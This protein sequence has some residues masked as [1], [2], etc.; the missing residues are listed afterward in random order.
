MRLLPLAVL[1]VGLVL[2]VAAASETAPALMTVTGEGEAVAVPDMASLSL[3]VATRGTT[4]AKALGANST[5]LAAV[6]AQLAADG[7][8][9]RDIQTSGLSVSPRYDYSDQ[10]EGRLLGYDAHNMVTVRVRDLARLGV[11]IDAAFAAGA[12]EFNGL[13]FSFADDRSAVD[14]ARRAAVAD[15]RA[16]AE[17]YAEA[18][19]VSLGRIVTITEAAAGNAPQPMALRAA[20]MAAPPVPIAAGE[21]SLGAQITVVY[22]IIQ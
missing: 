1:I 3:G 8:A 9:P 11:V 10:G 14:A 20:P 15:A 2:P 21:L 18:A 12:N 6:L 17:L 16:R 19:G 4:A 7:I 5:A 13:S 22:E